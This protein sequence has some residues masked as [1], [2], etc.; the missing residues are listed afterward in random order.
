MS[1]PPL[2]TATLEILR[3]LPTHE[4]GF[5]A[6]RRQQMRLWYADGTPSEPFVYDT[7]ERAALDAVVIVAHC[8]DADGRRSVFLR[9]AVR[10]PI[11]TRPNGAAPSASGATLLSAERAVLWEM[12]A[13]LVELH[14]VGETGLVQCA[15]RE[16]W[17]ELGIRAPENAFRRLGPPLFAEPGTIGEQNHY[18]EL[19]VDPSQRERPAEDGSVLEQRALVALVGVDEALELVAQGLIADAKTEIALRRLADLGSAR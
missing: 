15:A 14:E 18:F 16:L 8:R 11:A 6:L 10:P 1:L 9:S 17:E 7:I 12:P 2:P 4:R 13:G 3:E 19:R 5:L